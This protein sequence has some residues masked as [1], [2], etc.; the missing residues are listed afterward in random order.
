MND[1]YSDGALEEPVPTG[2]HDDPTRGTHAMFE[3]PE[4]C[5]RSDVWVEA[6]VRRD[7][8][9]FSA[10]CIKRWQRRDSDSRWIFHIHRMQ[11][12]CR[13]PLRELAHDV[14]NAIKVGSIRDSAIRVDGTRGFKRCGESWLPF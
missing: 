6:Y 10:L 7:F 4:H 12:E 14:L 2:L 9:R 1:A 3:H 5:P 8:E 11:F 13:M